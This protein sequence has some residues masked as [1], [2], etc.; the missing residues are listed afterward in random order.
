MSFAEKRLRGSRRPPLPELI[1]MLHPGHRP[2]WS[3][4][5]EFSGG[6]KHSASLTCARRP[7]GMDAG[8]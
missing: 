4:H 3:M 6:A 1:S 7:S 2:G 5:P 8:S